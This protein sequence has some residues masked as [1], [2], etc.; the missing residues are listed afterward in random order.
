V[1]ASDQGICGDSVCQTAGNP[2]NAAPERKL[3]RRARLVGAYTV[4]DEIDCMLC[5]GSGVNQKFAIIA[6]LL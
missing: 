5:L 3:G 6:K 1:G 4:Q 2:E